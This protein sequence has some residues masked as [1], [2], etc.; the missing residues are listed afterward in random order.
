MPRAVEADDPDPS[1][2][3]RVERRSHVPDSRDANVLQAARGGAA[4]RLGQPGAPPLG[5]EHAVHSRG[6]GGPQ[7]RAEVPR[8]FDSVEDDQERRL[9][10]LAEDGLE[11]E[12]RLGRDDRDEPL[13][14]H[15]D[16]DSIEGFS[17][18]EAEGD[19]HPAGAADGLGDP[20]VAD[21][22]DHEET[23]EVP[24]T[25]RQG[26]EN[27]VDAAD[28]VHSDP[29]SVGV[30]AA[31]PQERRCEGGDALGSAQGAEAVGRLRLDG[32]RVC[33]KAREGVKAPAD[34]GQVRG[35]AGLLPDHGDVDIDEREALPGDESQDLS[36][37]QRTVRTAPA[38]VPAREVLTHVARGRGPE[39]RVADRVENTVAVRVADEPAIAR[40]ADSTQHQGAPIR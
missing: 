1:G 13:M 39:Q 5:E 35:E 18:L 23:L 22:L 27:G 15:A 24:V 16:R 26:L 12:D 40:D 3:D 2:L 19:P 6:L 9:S 36:Q 29:I 30:H 25:G 17:R 37:K 11:V 4:D 7:D 8:V 33:G 14:G 38:F 21:P 10:R 20:P 31:S 34:L 28:Q 32:H